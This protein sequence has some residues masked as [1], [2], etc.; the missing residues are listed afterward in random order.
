MWGVQ[1]LLGHTCQ[2]IEEMVT[3][4]LLHQLS[5]SQE[6]IQTCYALLCLVQRL[7]RKVKDENDDDYIAN[8]KPSGYQSLHTAVIG[9]SPPPYP[10]LSI[11]PLIQCDV[12][13]CNRH[14]IRALHI[15]RR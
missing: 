11:R 4:V 14:S 15:C 3:V 12:L 8:P 10:I 5:A 9:T 7:W 2:A 1:C 13:T 6:A